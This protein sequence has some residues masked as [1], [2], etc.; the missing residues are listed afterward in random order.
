MIMDFDERAVK[1]MER[2]FKSG[3]GPI[4]DNLK[5]ISAALKGLECYPLHLKG[6]QANCAIII[7]GI[8]DASAIK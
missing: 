1:D 5:T 7:D 6:K 8:H 2:D 3:R 4:C